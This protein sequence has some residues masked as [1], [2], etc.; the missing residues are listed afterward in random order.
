MTD[1]SSRKSPQM[2]AAF[3]T[4]GADPL[5]IAERIIRQ[6][7]PVTA[8]EAVALAEAYKA[9]HGKSAEA[10]AAAESRG[11]FENGKL[12]ET[13]KDRAEAAESE[14]QRL[15][16]QLAQRVPCVL[17]IPD[18]DGSHYPAGH[19]GEKLCCVVRATRQRAEDGRG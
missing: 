18:C 10:I 13:L 5:A 17:G 4:Q 9:L 6:R 16:E 14:C 19:P 11:L 3:D 2:P 7:L 15:R 12:L 8:A 1:S